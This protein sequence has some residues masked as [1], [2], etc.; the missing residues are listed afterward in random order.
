MH[1]SQIGKCKIHTKYFTCDN[2]E[3]KLNYYY[4]FRKKRLGR[5]GINEIKEHPFFQND[6]WTFDNLRDCKK[7]I[8]K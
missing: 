3:S 6:Q 1:S 8:F 7:F 4:Y 2:N 5:N